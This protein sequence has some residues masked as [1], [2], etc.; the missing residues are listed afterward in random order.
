MP[1]RPPGI[2]CEGSLAT[3][4]LLHFASAALARDIE[5]RAF[6]N[7]PVGVNF[8]ITGYSDTRGGLSLDPSIPVTGAMFG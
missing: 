6:S 8:L 2:L 5:P 3:S 1:R 4:V 7:A